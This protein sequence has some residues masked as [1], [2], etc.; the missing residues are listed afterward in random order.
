MTNK[1]EKHQVSLFFPFLL[2]LR[3]LLYGASIGDSIALTALCSFAIFSLYTQNKNRDTELENKQQIQQLTLDIS[4]QKNV[5]ET[6]FKTELNELKTELNAWG[7]QVGLIKVDSG[8]QKP[9]NNP[10]NNIKTSN[11]KRKYF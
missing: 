8:F 5:I 2:L 3:I 7:Q 1:F 6:T 11:E 10:V 9:T 4:N